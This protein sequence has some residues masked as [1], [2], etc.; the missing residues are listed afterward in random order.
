MGKEQVRDLFQH[1]DVRPRR[2]GSGGIVRLPDCCLRSGSHVPPLRLATLPAAA[3]GARPVCARTSAVRIPVA[4]PS[5]KRAII[6]TPGEAN[7]AAGQRPGRQIRVNH[8]QD[9]LPVS[10]AGAPLQ[11]FLQIEPDTVSLIYV[12][13]DKQLLVEFRGQAR[14]SSEAAPTALPGAT[15][16]RRATACRGARSERSPY[17]QSVSRR[18][19]SA[20][21]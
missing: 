21:C 19:P 4:L 1:L 18:Y 15:P 7:P 11:V 17:D 20:R 16:P 13:G 9:S 14:L 2:S 5:G 6:E 12:S 8:K 10:F 3:A